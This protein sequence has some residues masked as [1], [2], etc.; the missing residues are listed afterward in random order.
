MVEIR[1]NEGNA[2]FYIHQDRTYRDN[3]GNI[4]DYM[5]DDEYDFMIERHAYPKWDGK[6]PDK[7]LNKNK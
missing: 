3:N 5:S 7:Y 2:L 1:D 4:I 6:V